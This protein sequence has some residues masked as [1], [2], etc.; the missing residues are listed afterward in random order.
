MTEILG[1][2]PSSRWTSGAPSSKPT[3]T[4]VCTSTTPTARSTGTPGWKPS[5]THLRTGSRARVHAR[6]TSAD[7]RQRHPRLLAFRAARQPAGRQRHGL[8]HLG[9]RKGEQSLRLRLRPEQR[10]PAAELTV[11]EEFCEILPADPQLAIEDCLA[12]ADALATPS[13]SQQGLPTTFNWDAQFTT[14]GDNPLVR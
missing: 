4:K 6:G 13:R 14:Q 3:S 12:V 1:I 11:P 2:G 10:R 7:C 5:A 9:R 8:R